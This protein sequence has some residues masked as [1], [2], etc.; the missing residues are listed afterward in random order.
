MLTQILFAS[1]E[2]MINEQKQHA[3]VSQSVAHISPALEMIAFFAFSVCIQKT[4]GFVRFASELF[5]LPTWYLRG[6]FVKGHSSFFVDSFSQSSRVVYGFRRGCALS[7]R[8][9]ADEYLSY[10]RSIFLLLLLRKSEYKQFI[11]VF[12][13]ALNEMTCCPVKGWSFVDGR[14]DPWCTPHSVWYFHPT[15]FFIVWFDW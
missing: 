10:S 9:K 14:I 1:I 5:V 4:F 13:R 12:L 6:A 7:N 8:A 2:S 11:C 15:F 3:K